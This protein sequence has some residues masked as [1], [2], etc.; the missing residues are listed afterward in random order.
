[1]TTVEP[2]RAEVDALIAS[3]VATIVFDLAD[4]SFLDSAALA[5]FSQTALRVKVRVDHPSAVVR[6]VLDLTGLTTL[7]NAGP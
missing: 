3:G 4:V 1:M 2:L 5:V 7:L 6:R